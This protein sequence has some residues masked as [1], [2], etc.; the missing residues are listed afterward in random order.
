M[1]ARL[2]ELRWDR[3]DSTPL[4]RSAPANGNG[5]YADSTSSVSSVR[6]AVARSDRS[7]SARATGAMASPLSELAPGAPQGSAPRRPT[8][9]R[10]SPRTAGRHRQNA[11]RVARTT[12]LAPDREPSARLGTPT[13]GVERIVVNRRLRAGLPVAAVAVA[14]A[15]AV[16]DWPLDWPFWFDHPYVAAFAAGLALLF[17]AGT[18]VDAYLRRREARRW[19]GLGFAAAGEFASILYDTSIT[20]AALAGVDNGYRLRSDVEFHLGPARARA[21]DLLAGHG[22]G[23][24]GEITP[25]ETDVEFDRRLAILLAD[26]RWRRSC[27]QTLRVARGQLVEA[28][29]RWTGTFAILNDDEH[30]NRVGRALMIM[31]LITALHMSLVAASP[32]ADEA[33]LREV[34]FAT[35]ARQWRMLQESVTTELDFWNARRRVGRGSTCRCRSRTSRG[36]A[37]RSS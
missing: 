10:G 17:V 23:L 26:E 16:S 13:P 4:E 1:D 34:G 15:L 35:F 36:R 5:A 31:D 25:E 33:H 11:G 8:A 9:A 30:F 24:T 18:I 22:A 21:G 2:Y 20:T 6:D 14:V 28:V 12:S 19:H 37:T 3:A 7:P 27:S 32:D 29:S